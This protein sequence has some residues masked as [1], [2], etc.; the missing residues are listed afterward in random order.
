MNHVKI[1]EILTDMTVTRLYVI[2]RAH[3]ST[4]QEKYSGV[5]PAL[6]I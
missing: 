5:N 4:G 6:L 1:P 3:N 2:L